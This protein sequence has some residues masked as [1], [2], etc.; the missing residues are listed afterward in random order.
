[1][2]TVSTI[3]MLRS[4]IGNPISR[5]ILNKIS[6]YCEKC[7]KNRTDVALEIFTG[8]RKDACIKCRIAETSISGILHAGSRAFGVSTHELKEKF[9]DPSWRKAISAL[10]C[11]I[12]RRLRSL[13]PKNRV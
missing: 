12:S 9:Q 1:M 11:G 6:G 13:R 5:G 8:V 10:F 4:T 7:K 3:Q 2:Q